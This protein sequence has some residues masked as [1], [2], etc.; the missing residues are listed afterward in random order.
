[1]QRAVA[2]HQARVREM[3][4]SGRKPTAFGTITFKDGHTSP[5]MYSGTRIFPSIRVFRK[6]I[7]VDR[8]AEGTT[9]ALVSK[10]S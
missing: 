5:T 1:M 7:L 4:R 3:T 6:P 10:Q 9:Q 8:G 2:D